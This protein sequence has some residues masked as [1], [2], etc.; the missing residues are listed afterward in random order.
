MQDDKITADEVDEKLKRKMSKY[1][2]L[3]EQGNIAN[4]DQI[5]ACVVVASSM[6]ELSIDISKLKDVEIIAIV[7]GHQ[8]GFTKKIVLEMVKG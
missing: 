3:C 2:A 7:K 1:Y 6:K 8:V 4:G 5:N